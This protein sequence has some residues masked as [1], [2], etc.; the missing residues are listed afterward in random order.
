MRGRQAR[1]QIGSSRKDAALPPWA[2]AALIGESAVRPGTPAKG[3]A[4]IPGAPS[5]QGA[6]VTN[7]LLPPFQKG[8]RKGRRKVGREGGREGGRAESAVS[9]KPVSKN[10]ERRDRAVS[11]NA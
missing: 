7:W 6:K 1:K 9:G 4:T 2:A 8:E 11:Y 10:S 3:E 5:S